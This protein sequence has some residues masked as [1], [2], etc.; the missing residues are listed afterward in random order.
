MESPKV[1]KVSHWLSKYMGW[2]YSPYKWPERNGNNW[3]DYFI[4]KWPEIITW[5]TGVKI[6]LVNSFMGK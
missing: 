3:G 5:L 1:Q 4:Y 6:P 2:L